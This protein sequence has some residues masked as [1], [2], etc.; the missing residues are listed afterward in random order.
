MR[1]NIFSLLFLAL[2]ATVFI[3]SCGKDDKYACD[4]SEFIGTYSGSH[5]L[6]INE[7]VKLS[8][9]INDNIT[10]ADISGT[11]SVLITSTT[12]GLTVRGIVSDCKILVAGATVDSFVY[13]LNNPIIGVAKIK[14]VNADLTLRFNITKD[15]L[16]TVIGVNEGTASSSTGILDNL[17]IANRELKGTFK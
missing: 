5:S 16:E 3:T 14:D 11:D 13:D 1:K 15:Q 9:P 7:P 10:V 12:L 8:I 17:S 2:I 6:S 4:K